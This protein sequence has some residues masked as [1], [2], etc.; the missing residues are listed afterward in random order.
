[1]V[2]VFRTS[3]T[4]KGEANKLLLKLRSE[5]PSHRINFDLTDAD[6]IL[7][8]ESRSAGEINIDRIIDVLHENNFVCCPL[9]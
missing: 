3:V 2:E 9:E 5:F 7:R 8:V 4:S 1:M 6:R